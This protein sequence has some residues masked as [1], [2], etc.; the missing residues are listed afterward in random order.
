MSY[1]TPC[2]FRIKMGFEVGP[3][4]FGGW[5]TCPTE[6]SFSE[7]ATLCHCDYSNLQKLLV[8]VWCS[9]IIGE[10]ETAFKAFG[11]VGKRLVWVKW[12][13]HLLFIVSDHCLGDKAMTVE[14]V[15]K[16]VNWGG[17][18][19][20]FIGIIEIVKVVFFNSCDD[21][22]FNEE[23]KGFCHFDVIDADGV[24]CFSAGLDRIRCVVRD[25]GII[26]S[27]V[28]RDYKMFSSF[29]KILCI[30][31]F[32]TK[33]AIASSAQTGWDGGGVAVDLGLKFAERN[34]VWFTDD[35]GEG[36]P[37]EFGQDGLFGE[38][39]GGLLKCSVGWASGGRWLG[40]WRRV[41]RR[42]ISVC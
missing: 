38:L 36:F 37:R 3:C 40:R 41:E 10:L 24:I 22:V 2:V 9:S 8:G 23:G 30:R 28:L 19:D 21:L 4:F 34:V 25:G 6:I 11:V 42:L 26:V 32:D 35:G 15:Q 27:R 33:M 1:A 12:L 20:T 17:M 5:N 7:D 29:L 18:Q 31:H 13:V 14:D 39:H 16:K